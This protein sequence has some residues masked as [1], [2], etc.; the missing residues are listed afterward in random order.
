MHRLL[1]R[2]EPWSCAR[3]DV[4]GTSHFL[5]SR[6]TRVREPSSSSGEWKYC[7]TSRPFWEL[8]VVPASAAPV[9]RSLHQTRI[10]PSPPPRNTPSSVS[11]LNNN[12]QVSFSNPE[13]H[14]RPLFATKWITMS[15]LSFQRPSMKDGYLLGEQ[16]DD[17]G[18]DIYEKPRAS[19]PERWSSIPRSLL[20]Y[21]TITTCYSILI[22]ALFSRQMVRSK[23]AGPDI[24]YS[25]FCEHAQPFLGWPTKAPARK[26]MD[27]RLTGPTSVYPNQYHEH[28]Y[29][30]D[31]SVELDQR[32]INRLRCKQTSP[33]VYRCS[34][35]SRFHNSPF[36]QGILALQPKRYPL[37]GRIG[38]SRNPNGIP[39]PTLHQI[40]PRDRLPEI[41]LP[42][43]HGGEEAW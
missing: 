31:P 39:R 8:V 17:D 1:W 33:P 42:Q 19:L 36:P 43:R 5:P 21:A 2:R 40:P 28:P 34:W 30:G 4:S 14:Q 11:S 35:P 27:Y 16:S 15:F 41:L 13:P 24:I 29:F 18:S 10:P 7:C 37:G 6:D 26:V 25:K 9:G 23:Y 38:L 32:W 3:R 22:T 20:I 12:V